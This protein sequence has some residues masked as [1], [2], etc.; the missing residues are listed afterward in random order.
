MAKLSDDDYRKAW[1]H[2]TNSYN[3]DGQWPPT[4][5]NAPHIIHP[6]N[7]GYCFENLLKAELLVGGVDRTRLET[8]PVL[9]IREILGLQQKL[10]LKKA[11]YLL[12]NGNDEQKRAAGVARTLIRKSQDG[13]SIDKEGRVLLPSEYTVRAEM[14]VE[15]RQLV[16]GVEIEVAEDMKK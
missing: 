12:K 13:S 6:F 4:L 15:A 8:D 7:Y 1:L 16:G 9:T 2:L 5:P 11:D 3:S 10:I 14:M